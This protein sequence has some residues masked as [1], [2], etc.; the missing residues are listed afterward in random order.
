[1]TQL[2]EEY[3]KEAEKIRSSF[4]KFD[5]SITEDIGAG[6]LGQAA[7]RLFN[8]AVG[9]IP[10]MIQAFVPG[11]G[12]ASI[13]LG[14]AAQKS[15]ELQDRGYGLG[16]KTSANSIASGTA[17]GLAD[18]VTK[19]IGGKFFTSLA[20]KGKD[21]VVKSIGKFAKEF[22]ID[23]VEEGAS[24]TGSL[25]VSKLA[26]YAISGDK[27]AF[28]DTLY[29]FS[30]TFLVGG[31]ATGPLSGGKIGIDVVGQNARKRL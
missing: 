15:K 23:F 28:D 4:D 16:L 31:F 29:E 13:G 19:K 30:D 27:K 12:I 21:Y 9:A 18:L 20:G 8:E 5:T 17:E 2:S 26:D 10:S 24:E 11:V 25:L 22:G 3:T 1:M 7:G 6:D 14:S